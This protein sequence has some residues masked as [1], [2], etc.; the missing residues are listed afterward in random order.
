VT[1]PNRRTRLPRGHEPNTVDLGGAARGTGG[2]ARAA[3]ARH[4]FPHAAGPDDA[5]ELLA[6]LG[7]ID[8]PE[9]PAP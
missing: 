1:R 8:D 4:R 2:Q 3:G 9:Q 7:L 6:M 5:R